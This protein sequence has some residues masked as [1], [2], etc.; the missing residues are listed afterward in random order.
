MNILIDGRVW[1][2]NAAG[3]TSFLS[4]ALFSWAQ[5]R[6]EDTL[7]VLLP[8]G[9]DASLEL[10]SLPGNIRLLDYSHSFPKRL[11]NI[12]ILQ[13]L[14]PHLCRKYAIDLYYSP[15][16]HL[17]FCLPARVKTMVTV[18]DV[19]NL[20]MA[21]TMAWTNWLAS[22]MSFSRSVRQAD[23]LWTNSRYT[24]ER[25]EHYFPQRRAKD[26]FVGAAVDRSLFYPRHLSPDQKQDVRKR[27]GIQGQ[28]ALFVGSLEPRKNLDF[29]LRLMPE[30]YKENIRLVVVGGKGW[31]NSSLKK[32]IDAPGFPKEA[33]IFCGY[34]TNDE[35]ALLYNTADCFVSAALMEGFGMPQLEAL[36]CGCP[37]VTADNTAMTEIASGKQGATLVSGYDPEQWRQTVVKVI[38]EHPDVDPKQLEAYDW[39]R[40]ITQ[41]TEYLDA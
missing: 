32:T 14:V 36:L 31:K 41:L 37:I 34:V 10:T 1:S 17:P 38:S 39:K 5:L 25:V 33:V 24:R 29:L 40:I 11:P 4:G 3:V 7:F 20:E 28:F 27:Y 30:L 35:L 9:L 12:L 18:H 6:K 8:K 23:Y 21:Q 19:V 13:L 26:I 16:P 2:R 22:R 15:V